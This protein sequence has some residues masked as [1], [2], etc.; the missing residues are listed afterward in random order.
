MKL[1]SFLTGSLWKLA[2]GGATIMT[3]ILSALLM[4][5][6]FENRSL[7]SQ[8]DELAQQINDPK[9]GYIAQLAQSRTNVAQLQLALTNQNE[10]YQKLKNDSDVAL[11]AS[12]IKLQ[13]AKTE[14]K[15]AERKLGQFLSTKPQGSSLEQRI[16][17]IDQR[18]LRE[19]VP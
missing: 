17:D 3:L 8:R 11:K 19:L 2:F 7:S 1:P 14:T 18:A 5:S 12:A 10:A 15:I 13:A 9:T 4:A 6:Y 16:Q